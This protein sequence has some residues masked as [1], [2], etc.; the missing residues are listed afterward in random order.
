MNQQQIEQLKAGFR[1][2]VEAQLEQPIEQINPAGPHR[3]AAQ[4]HGRVVR[5]ASQQAALHEGSALRG[6]FGVRG[7]IWGRGGRLLYRW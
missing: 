7:S 1:Q 4:T 3:G 2:I 6:V 5:E